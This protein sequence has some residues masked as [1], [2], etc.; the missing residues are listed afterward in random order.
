MKR[1]FISKKVPLPSP[2]KQGENKLA[3]INYVPGECELLKT[4]SNIENEDN[5]KLSKYLH[6]DMIWD[7]IDN[8]RILYMD[9]CPSKVTHF[10]RKE[11]N[12]KR[13]AFDDQFSTYLR[14]MGNGNY[15]FG[16]LKSK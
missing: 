15:N 12:P 9:G 7:G 16:Q 4:R 3:N 5:F 8:K 1:K 13:H 6:G 2:G 11:N 14:D 10:T